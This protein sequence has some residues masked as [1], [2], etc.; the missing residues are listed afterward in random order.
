MEPVDR[1]VAAALLGEVT[2]VRRMVAADPALLSART[3]FGAGA[4]HAAHYGGQAAV[5]DALGD[6][7]LVIDGFLAAEL[8]RIDELRE[9]MAADPGFAARFDERGS[10]ALHGAVYWGQRQAAG[11]LLDAGADPNAVTRDGFLQIAP[12]G[13]AIAS[14]PGIPQPSDSEDNVLGLVRLLL[15]RGANVN[16]RRRDGMTA[17]H[18]ACWRGLSRVAQE[19]LDAGADP[20]ITATSGPHQGQTPADTARS[21]GHLLLAGAGPQRVRIVHLPAAAFRALADGDLAAANTVSPVP[22]PEYF[23]SP[24]WRGTWRRRSEQ[25]KQDPASAAWVTG[26]IWDEQR[27]AA[28]G[29][30]G[31]HGP[32]DRSGMVEIGYAVDPA[33]R[34]RGYARAALE[35]LL[36]RAAREP[37]VRVVRVSISP[38]NTASYALASQYGF[39]RVGEQ[40]DEEDGLEIIY[41]V[42]AT[43]RNG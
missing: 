23:V 9:A 17:L 43:P 16:G 2:Q 7:G 10:T 30:A 11:L 15:E 21:Q 5:L 6:L 8:G 29:R 36:E 18:T 14:T 40:W 26:V 27:Q 13:S 22:L 24:Q 37:Q 4:V 3:M 42:A 31:Y 34:R 38:D 12:L 19:L 35:T 1:L 33:Y 39:V 32:P 20:A 41:E 28:V 25:V